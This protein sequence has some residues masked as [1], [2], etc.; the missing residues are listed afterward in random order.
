MS[1]SDVKRRRFNMSGSYQGMPSPDPYGGHGPSRHHHHHHHHHSSLSGPTVA[2]PSYSHGPGSALPGPSILTR[3]GPSM[4]PPPSRSSSS[5][6]HH[7]PTSRRG[8]GFDD[9]LRLPPL[10][11]QLSAS[12]ETDTGTGSARP[13]ID[14]P[15]P[16]PA[17][18]TA[19]PPVQNAG[20]SLRE[21]QARSIEAMVM[22]I[23]YINKLKVLERISPPLAPPSPS[24]PAI[25]TRGAVIA[26]EGANPT[27]IGQVATLVER[28]LASSGECAVRAWAGGEIGSAAADEPAAQFSS[29]T[30]PVTADHGGFGDAAGAGGNAD[31]GGLSRGPGDLFGSYLRTMIDWHAK[32]AE[33]V[34]HI[35]TAPVPAER[36]SN[37]SSISAATT[38]TTSTTGGGG[39]GGSTAGG[40]SGGQPTT[41]AGG[42]ISTTDAPAPSLSSSSP[43]T[44]Q[45]RIPVALVTGGF[46]LTTSDR[47]A[48]KVPIADSYAPVDHWQWMATLWRGIV[49]PDLVV[50][51]R[52]ASDEEL[53][54]LQAV[55]LK[56]PGI[57]MVRVHEGTGIV[58]KTERRLM[59]EVVEWV[60]AGTFKEGLSRRGDS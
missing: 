46:S 21:S 57:M 59:F 60:R 5:S 6:F 7:P 25:E 16:P 37:A 31:S 58:E 48:C 22:S 3:S 13:V 35:T 45:G 41:D 30:A 12:H 39:G 1:P 44:R 33:M 49:G 17:V 20:G 29:H 15:P 27:L 38:T 43:P 54:K 52:S 28:A 53:G 10:Q 51:V 14:A 24:S 56:A 32:S 50:Y 55:E 23:P 47:F 11:T 40:P 36:S 26:I 42:G 9:S 2:S 19:A 4:G 34:K 8:S 18:A